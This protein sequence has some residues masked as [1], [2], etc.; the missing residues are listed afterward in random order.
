MQLAANESLA[1]QMGDR[2][3]LLEADRRSDAATAKL[4][5]RAPPGEPQPAILGQERFDLV[6]QGLRGAAADRRQGLSGR[7]RAFSPG[8]GSTRPTGWPA[9][10]GA[11]RRGFAEIEHAIQQ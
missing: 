2:Q 9:P 5:R 6:K 8:G 11:G 10:N 3:V 1:P 7:P 4:R